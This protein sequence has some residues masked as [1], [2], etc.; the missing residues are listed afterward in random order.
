MKLYKIILSS[1]CMAGMTL[2]TSCDDFLTETPKHQLVEENAVRDYESAKNIVNGMYSVYEYATDLGG[3]ATSNLNCQAGLWDYS[4][5]HFNMTYT[6]S[7]NTVGGIWKS[8]YKCINAA[9]AAINS[10]QIASDNIFPTPEAKAKLIAE[11][12][13]FRGYMN[14]QLLWYFGHWFDEAESPYGI[15]YRDQLANLGNLMLDRSTV[16]QSYQYI[17]DDFEYAEEN[18][19]D[20]TTSIYMSKQFA[21][22]MHAKMLT[23]RGWEGDYQKALELVNAVLSNPGASAIEPDITKLY[24]DAWDNPELIFAQNKIDMIATS[25]SNYDSAGWSDYIWAAALFGARYE[26]IPTA[27]LE[28]DPRHD[29]IFGMAYGAEK[30]QVTEGKQELT[31]KKLYHEGRVV[32]PNAK[33]C[34][35]V[36]RL[37]ELYILKAELLARTN[38][39]DLAGAIAPIN[40]YRAK[41][42]NP[43]LPAIPVPTTHE[44]LM[45]EIFKEYVVSLFLENDAVWFAAIRFQTEGDTWLKKL[46]GNEISYTENQYCWPIPNEEI[47]AHT[48]KIEQN[49]DLEK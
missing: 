14:L 19:E 44:S 1:L 42:T 7:N 4:M 41:Y 49:P 27:W 36:L 45:D 3:K 48:N 32:E 31:L 13:C 28:E 38:P 26:D 34:T 25:S 11:A 39:G 8:L 33:Y 15:I 30:W 21:Q 2:T 37:T 6:Q 18:L 46:K 10:I 16:G 29:Y 17:L 43:I 35:Y 24:N 22:A 9:N 23:I 12:R 40:E 47:I 20:H 5:N